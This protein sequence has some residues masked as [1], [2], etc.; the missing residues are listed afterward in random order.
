MLRMRT[1]KPS[2]LETYLQTY[3]KVNTGTPITDNDFER[4]SFNAADRLAVSIGAYDG[5]GGF[6]QKTLG[7]L[8]AEIDRLQSET[9]P[10][11]LNAPLGVTR[12]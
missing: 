3:A 12:G 2:L 1:E 8:K 10:N 4:I 7:E 11:D 5:K 9:K 6:A